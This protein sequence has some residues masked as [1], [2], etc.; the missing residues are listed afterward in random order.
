MGCLS[1]AALQQACGCGHL[2]VLRCLDSPWRSPRLGCALGC[3]ADMPKV[4][5]R[6]RAA[7]VAWLA[8]NAAPHVLPHQR[9]GQSARQALRVRLMRRLRR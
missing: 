2:E 8:G 1:S 3:N 6:L 9:P 5:R 4:R 7:R